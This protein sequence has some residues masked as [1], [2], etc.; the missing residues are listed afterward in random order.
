[1]TIVPLVFA[2]QAHGHFLFV[3]ITPP[4]EAGRAVEAYFSDVAEAGDPQFIGKIAHTRLWAQTSPGSF[5]P[6]PAHK[7]ADR[8]RAPLPAARSLVV[9]GACEYGVLSRKTP[10]LLRHFPKAVAGTPEELN[11]MKPFDKVPLEIVAQVQEDGIRLAALREGKP[12]PNA[13]FF[14]AGRDKKANQWKAGP[15]GWITWT[16]PKPGHYSIYTSHVTP[17]S[18]EHKGKKYEEIRDFATLAFTWPLTPQVDPAAVALFQE[19]LAARAV[20]KDFPGFRADVSGKVDGRAFSGTVTVAADGSVDLNVKD[21]AARDWLHGQLESIVLHRGAGSTSRSSGQKTPN[22][23][24]ADAETDH[25]LGRLL[26][27]A[28]GRFASSYR[29]QERQIRVVNRHM[30][31]ETM[32]ITVL[33]ND[34]NKEGKFLPRTYTVQYWDAATGKLKHMETVQERWHRLGSWDLPASQTITLASDAGLAVRSF[35][36]SKHELLKK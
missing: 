9:V 3:R 19:A 36:L 10:F 16:P 22:I 2:A 11:R 31:K 15:D 6:V 33:D 14:L 13:V 7:G 35:S 17:T 28:G 34:R 8:L 27:F 29:V 18:G 12:L 5:Q 21:E 20:W 24:F 32:T 25:P 1:M 26:L 30:G 4:A 23:S